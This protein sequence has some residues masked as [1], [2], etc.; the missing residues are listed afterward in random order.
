M[1]SVQA[2]EKFSNSNAQQ[3]IQANA[4]PQHI[5]IQAPT[6]HLKITNFVMPSPKSTHIEDKSK[7]LEL[8]LKIPNQFRDIY[9]QLKTGAVSAC[10]ATDYGYT[11]KPDFRIANGYVMIELVPKP[12]RILVML[13]VDGDTN[14][15]TGAESFNGFQNP[16]QEAGK[17]GQW[18]EFSVNNADQ[19]QPAIN[20]IANAYQYRNKNPW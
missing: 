4:T 9:A 7:F 6:P 11:N 5:L 14:S 10:S 3:F 12:D 13:R 20:L 8:L 16:A 17:P 2:L 1:T 15:I 19:I 18:I